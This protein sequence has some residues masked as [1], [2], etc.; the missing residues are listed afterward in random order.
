MKSIKLSTWAKQQGISYRTAWNWYR[1]G[2]LPAPARQTPTGTILVEVPDESSAKANRA[3]L[4]ARVS[5]QDQKLQLDGQIARCLAFANGAGLSV[6]QT[7]T[8]VGSGVTGHRKKLLTLLADPKVDVIVVDRRDRLMRF[9]AEYVEAALNARGARL[10]VVDETECI[11]DLDADMI[12]LLTSFCARHY[13]QRSAANRA[14]LLVAQC[15]NDE[16]SDAAR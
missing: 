13:D 8:E 5:S 9:G 1:T 4:Y 15:Q 7:V 3:A 2:Q 6:G 14:K 11:D 16:E 10:M 12:A